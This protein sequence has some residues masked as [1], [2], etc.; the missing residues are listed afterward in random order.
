M[1]KYSVY[2]IVVYVVTL[3]LLFGYL[4]WMWLRLRALRNESP[5]QEPARPIRGGGPR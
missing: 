3:G 4:A 2:V 5:L 1:D